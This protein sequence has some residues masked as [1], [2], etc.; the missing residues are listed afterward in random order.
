[1]PGT[2]LFDDRLPSLSPLADLRPAWDIRTGA[3]TT[4]ERVEA[5]LG[6]AV[7]GLVCGGDLADLAREGDPRV[8][9]PSDTPAGLYLN[10]RCV[11]PPDRVFSL[12]MGETLVDERGETVAAMVDHAAAGRLLAGDLGGLRAITSA[13]PMLTR[14]WHV[15]THRDACLSRDMALLAAK[16]PFATSLPACIAFGPQRLHVAAS[17]RIYPGVTFDLELG[18]IVI[19]ER[20]VIRPGAQLIGPCYV[21]RDSTILER[22]TIR[23]GTAV[24]P[25]CK[26]N[27]EV[28][29][30][31]FQ[32]FSN[33]AHDGY[34]GDSYLGEW[35]N[36]GA[37]TTTSN[38]LNT[39][40][41]II[42]KASPSLGN[43]RTGLQY[44]GSVI[45]D[46]VKTA[47]CTRLMT[48]TVVH[49]GAMIATT[50]AAS[51]CVL[52]FAWC[53]DAGTR[54]FRLD[55]FTEIMRTAMGRRKVEPT[56]AYV[57]RVAELHRLALETSPKG[58]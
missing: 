5:T 35:V 4:L 6:R 15:R 33:K 20:A 32:G 48:G 37:G 50:A 43:E 3:F 26:V 45:G 40:G 31:I 28:G 54:S 2:F 9:S 56:A 38:L 27:G 51:G 42:A 1:M 34:V 53:T 13:A 52:P 49:T 46:H 55:K 41:E 22:A 44:L 58:A 16:I 19:D 17:A 39:Y 25:V 8:L 12:A 30:T 11:L 47:I 24:G 14:P 21:G 23:P 57:A 18:P 29:G 7:D 36:L 10:A